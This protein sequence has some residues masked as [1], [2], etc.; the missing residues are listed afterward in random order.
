MPWRTPTAPELAFWRLDLEFHGSEK[1]LLAVLAGSVE[2]FVRNGANNAAFLA[3]LY[4]DLLGRAIDPDGEQYWSN[5]LAVTGSRF[6]VARE[7][8]S[9]VEF[10]ELL[11]DEPVDRFL[12]NVGW[13]QD[14][15]KR[16]AEDSGRAFWLN[17]LRRSNT[18]RTA[19]IG[20]L[21]SAEYYRC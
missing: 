12:A 18:W 20:I 1:R 13:Y 21:A 15:L 2:Y 4:R 8:I 14:Y 9:S 10:E 6:Q 19:Q 3:A 17:E 7:I 16:N 5:R 11:I